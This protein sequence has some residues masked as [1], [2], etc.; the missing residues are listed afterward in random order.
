MIQIVINV[1]NIA[2]TVL[3]GT[4]VGIG[5][6]MGSTRYIASLLYGVKGTDVAMTLMPLATIAAAVL[7]AAVPAVRRALKVDPVEMLRAE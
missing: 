5:L 4:V 6:G 7:L 3:L 1:V 2:V